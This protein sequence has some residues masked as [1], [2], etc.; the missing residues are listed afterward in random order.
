MF[1]EQ[2]F[3]LSN[4]PTRSVNDSPVLTDGLFCCP[5][6]TKDH[7]MA[8]RIIANYS[9]RL[10]LPGYSSHQF[11]VSVEAEL[12]NTD[13]VTSEASRLYKTLQTAVD[14]EMQS[15]GFVPCGEYGAVEQAPALEAAPV[16]PHGNGSSHSKTWKASDKQRELVLKLVENANLDIEVV[17]SLSEEMFGHGDLPELNKIQMS[18]LIDELLSRYGKRQRREVAPTGRFNGRTGR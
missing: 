9:K 3:S 18:G 10:G 13:N 11:S 4:H 6:A 17:E 15:T 14:R 7:H 16:R 12:A 1:P 8:V 5:D 2:G